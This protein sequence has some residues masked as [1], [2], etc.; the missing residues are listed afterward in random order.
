MFCSFEFADFAVGET[1][2]IYTTA[3]T[4]A[5]IASQS[6]LQPNTSV[7]CRPSP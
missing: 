1:R 6:G 2:T 7:V 4:R 5:P 3:A